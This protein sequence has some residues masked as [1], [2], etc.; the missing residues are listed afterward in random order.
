MNLTETYQKLFVH[1]AKAMKCCDDHLEED[2][3]FTGS[4]WSLYQ[5]LEHLAITGRSTPKLILDALS[6][7]VSTPLNDSGHLLFKLGA[8]PRG[9]TQAPD[10]AHP[11]GSSIKKIKQGFV[12]L[13]VALKDFELQLDEMETS[14]GRS[15]HPALGGLRAKEWVVFLEMHLAHHLKIIDDELEQKL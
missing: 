10:F 15:E 12:R 7:Q 6:G 3:T 1:I 14:E 9:E 2:Q 8:F 13:K 4:Q 5:H 11:K